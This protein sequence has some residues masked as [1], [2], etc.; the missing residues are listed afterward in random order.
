MAAE[1]RL[2]RFQVMALLQAARY[3]VLTGDKEKAFS[4]GLNRAIFYAWAKR[5]GVP[6]AASRERVS[7][8]V[9]VTREENR[10]VAYVGDEQ[11]YVSSNGWFTIGDEEQRPED[12]EREVIRRVEAVMPFEEAWRLAVEYV[13]SFDRRVL[14]SQRDFYEKVYLPVRDLFPN[15]NIRKSG[16]QTTLF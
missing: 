11:A 10:I 4:F 15:I 13:S 8:G 1:S 14:L 5:R 6:V 7:R 16:K 9:E 3:F 12:F 2:G